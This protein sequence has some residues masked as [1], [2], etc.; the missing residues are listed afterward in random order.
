MG[1]KTDDPSATVNSMEFAAIFDANGVETLQKSYDNLA[2]SGRLIIYGFHTNL[3]RAPTVTMN[4]NAEGKAGTKPAST[5]MISP[6]TWLRI[7]YGLLFGGMPRFDPMML[8][9]TSK[10]V[11]GFNLSFFSREIEMAT[12]YSDAII[13]YIERDVIPSN[14]TVTVLDDAREGHEL[15]STGNSVGKIVVS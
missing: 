11:M 13:G 7:L 2:Q 6:F 5:L 1:K 4:K 8:T 12:V 9:L 3:P 14:F 15:L 10:A